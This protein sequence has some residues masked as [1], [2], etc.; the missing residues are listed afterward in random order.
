MV[1]DDLS[2]CSTPGTPWTAASGPRHL[3][4]CTDHC[5]DREGLRLHAP[6]KPSRQPLP[7]LATASA[8]FT[9]DLFA[10]RNSRH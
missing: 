5:G 10:S 6:P 4:G 8:T 9:E 1:K 7:L 2:L 3:R